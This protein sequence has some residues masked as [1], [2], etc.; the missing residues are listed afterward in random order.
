MTDTDQARATGLDHGWRHA[1]FVDAC[2]ADPAMFLDEII[3][4]TRPGWITSASE[5]WAYR[6]GFDAGMEQFEADQQDAETL[7]S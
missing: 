6:D 5:Q 7:E 3:A 1:A 2:G 4:M